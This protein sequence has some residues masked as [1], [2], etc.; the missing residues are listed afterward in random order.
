MVNKI[1]TIHLNDEQPAHRVKMVWKIE[2]F[3][4]NQRK[5]HYIFSKT[6]FCFGSPPRFLDNNIV[7]Y[8]M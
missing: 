8:F 3:V 2:Y 7:L 1:K 4:F 5:M 6:R